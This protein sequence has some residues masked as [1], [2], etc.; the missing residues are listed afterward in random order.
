MD[1]HWT[2][3]FEASL[4]VSPRALEEVPMSFPIHD[5]S[6]RC[7]LEPRAKPYF[8]RLSD[9]IHIGYRKGKCVSRW[10]VRRYDGKAYR[11]KTVPGVYPDDNQSADG[12]RILSYQQVVGKIMSEDAKIPL[13]CS[14]CGKGHKQ[15]GTLI[16]GPSVFICDACVVLCQIY[17]DHPDRKGEKLLFDENFKPVLKDGEPVF[18]PITV[19]E[20]KTLR[21]RYDLS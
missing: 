4:L 12:R 5:R 2:L 3:H 16:A 13:Q 1:K 8:A 20:K 21:D 6:Q 9:G 17:L 18:V 19:E 14:F 10:V 7:T 15:V 11:M